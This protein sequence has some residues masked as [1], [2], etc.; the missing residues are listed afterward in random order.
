M[1]ELSL[2]EKHTLAWRT[3]PCRRKACAQPAGRRCVEDG[4]RVTPHPERVNDIDRF[5]EGAASRGPEVAALTAQLTDLNRRVTEA[6]DDVAALQQALADLRTAY[7]AL[8]GENTGLTEQLGALTRNLEATTAERD[9]LQRRVDELEHP[10][11]DPEPTPTPVP[12]AGFQIGSAYLSNG[13]PTPWEKRMGVV[14]DS[15]RTYYQGSQ[16]DSAVTHVKANIAAGRAVSSISFKVPQS[17]AAMATGAG[18][19]WAQQVRTKLQAARAA[20]HLIRI[21]FNHEPENDFGNDTV[22]RDDWKAMQNRLAPMFDL[23]GFEY[24]VIFMGDHQ[25]NSGANFYAAWQIDKAM[26]SSPAIKGVGYDIYERRGQI[27]NGTAMGWSNWG[28]LDKAK[29]WHA[30]RRYRWG[31]SETGW[32]EQAEAERPGQAQLMVDRLVK[33]GGS[34]LE[35]FNTNLN[36]AATWAMAAGSAREKSFAQALKANQR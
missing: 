8:T 10:T 3:L 18:D 11:P 20:G 5:L 29:A 34:W 27:K 14:L 23:P 9:A 21:A 19:T 12:A 28:I 17:W 16:L 31:L 1:T 25:Y 30:T 6:A 26:P 35:Y 36:S 15:R 13:D 33:A 22:K 24:V 2:A 7:Q 32:T 4:V